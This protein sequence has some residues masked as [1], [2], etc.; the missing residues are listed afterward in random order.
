MSYCQTLYGSGPIAA[1]IT[2]NYANMH[3]PR[4]LEV[5]KQSKWLVFAV[6]VTFYEHNLSIIGAFDERNR[7]I[8]GA[9]QHSIIGTF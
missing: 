7:K 6:K 2:R 8:L 5:V 4:I 1:N 9:V 3:H